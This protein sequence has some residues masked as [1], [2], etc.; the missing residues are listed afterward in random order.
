MLH[1]NQEFYFKQKQRYGINKN[2]LFI[3]LG[4]LSSLILIF[5]VISI[6]AKP[7]LDALKFVLPADLILTVVQCIS[8]LYVADFAIQLF[9]R[10]FIKKPNS[11][12]RYFFEIGSVLV[13]G[14]CIILLFSSFYAYVI[15][16]EKISPEFWKDVNRSR[17]IFMDFQLLVY[18][19]MRGFHFFTFLK[20][21]EIE[22][23]KW[24]KDISQSSFEALKNQL[25]P[26]FLFNS[27]SVLISLI[28]SDAAK[29]DR[30]IDRLSK[31]YRYLLDQRD[32][33][34]I[35]LS[36]ELEF[37]HNFGYLLAER[38]SD[39]IKIAPPTGFK[40]TASVIP[41][42]LILIIEHLIAGNKMSTSRPL[43]VNIEVDN[44]RLNIRHTHSPKSNLKVNQQLL[45]LQERYEQLSSKKI[46]ISRAADEQCISIP[47]LKD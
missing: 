9:D 13:T 25:N 27:F 5:L 30:F 24:Q 2:V 37:L 6:K 16:P 26:H 40:E 20:K 22:L 43:I 21:K 15:V 42:T 47:L 19:F 44:D 17:V 32:K 3:L 12:F 23:I 31:A 7:T 10:I 14:F 39:K 28:H 8:F 46:E 4:I 35:S 33:E 1:N 36:T 34:T 41:Y 11:F 45:I 18:A 29:A 38:F